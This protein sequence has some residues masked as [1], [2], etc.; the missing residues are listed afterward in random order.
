MLKLFVAAAL[1][2]VFAWPAHA[3]QVATPTH[4]CNLRST[5]STFQPPI[6]M[7]T[8]GSEVTLLSTA[9]K[10]GYFS[11]IVNNS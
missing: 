10:S 9:K 6:E 7:I 5:A 1:I 2:V 4:N 8:A 11:C 3:Q